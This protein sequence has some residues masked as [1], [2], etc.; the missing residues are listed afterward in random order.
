MER[1]SLY[2]TLHYRHQNDYAEVLSGNE[3][4]EGWGERGPVPLRQTV[5]SQNDS[6]GI[7]CAVM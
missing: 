2:L 5:I 4:K 6:A 3:I 1:G 7:V